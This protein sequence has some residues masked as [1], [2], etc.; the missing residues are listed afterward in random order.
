[1]GAVIAVFCMAV[2]YEGLKTLREYLVY[3]DYKH[4]SSHSRAPNAR[5]DDDIDDDTDR[6]GLLKRRFARAR[7]KG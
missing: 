7:P 1:M 5:G 4:W 3:L 6:G 2:L